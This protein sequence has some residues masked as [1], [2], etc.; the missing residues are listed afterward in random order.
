LGIEDAIRQFRAAATQKGEFGESTAD[1]HRSHLEMA[2]AWRELHS[3]G[4]AG[5]D[6]FKRLLTDDSGW[7]RGWVAAQLLSV[8]DWDAVPVL[9]ELARRD[10][11]CGFSART[12]LAQ[13]RASRLSSPFS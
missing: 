13:W 6:A 11:L 9:E 1:D 3:Q 4:D 8:G 5:R 7:V 10:G 2:N 12:T